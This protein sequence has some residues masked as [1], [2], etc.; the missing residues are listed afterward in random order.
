MSIGTYTR[1]NSIAENLRVKVENLLFNV[2]ILCRVFGR[3]KSDISVKRKS[4][5]IQENIR[6]AGSSFRMQLDSE[7]QSTSLR[8]ST[9]YDNCSVSNF[10]AMTNLR[11]LTCR[12][13]L[14]FQ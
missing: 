9:S 14:R 11:Q 5:T 7:L 1:Y 6:L 4:T 12:P 10:L 3:G 2:G 8:T 13:T